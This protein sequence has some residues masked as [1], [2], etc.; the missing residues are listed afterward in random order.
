VK[1]V[2]ATTG[3][4]RLDTADDWKLVK[5]IS[6]VPNVTAKSLRRYYEYHF[7]GCEL[8]SL[9]MKTKS[10]EW[11]LDEELE[12]KEVY[13]LSTYLPVGFGVIIPNEC[14]CSG[15]RCIC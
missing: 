15:V 5:K 2:L 12:L 1:E 13:D 8:S 4:Q 6:N 7:K 11:A 10:M 9:S 3:K 14:I